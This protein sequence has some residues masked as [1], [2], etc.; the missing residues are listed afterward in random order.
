LDSELAET[1]RTITIDHISDEDVKSKKLLSRADVG[2]YASLKSKLCQNLKGATILAFP[3]MVERLTANLSQNKPEDLIDLLNPPVK[4]HKLAWEKEHFPNLQQS[5][6]SFVPLQTAYEIATGQAADAFL[7]KQNKFFNERAQELLPLLEIAWSHIKHDPDVEK[8]FGNFLDTFSRYVKFCKNPADKELRQQEENTIARIIA[9]QPQLWSV[10]EKQSSSFADTDQA[11]QERIERLRNILGKALKNSQ[12]DIGEKMLGI[13]KSQGA[14]AL[15][16]NQVYYRI[17][18]D[19][20]G[21]F[22]AKDSP[23]WK[24]EL[25]ETLVHEIGRID[26]RLPTNKRPW[27]LNLDVAKRLWSF[28]TSQEWQ[29]RTQYHLA[30]LAANLAHYHPSLK[31]FVTKPSWVTSDAYDTQFDTITKKLK[32]NS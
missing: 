4:K 27:N 13:L 17:L 11:I 26:Y 21:P 22:W 20:A 12:H 29:Y 1:L 6:E 16:D 14:T 32:Q 25:S 23:L 31:K 19:P 10:I 5:L 18:E 15:V 7:S 9:D 2:P 30:E 3:N 24:E 8:N 28:Y